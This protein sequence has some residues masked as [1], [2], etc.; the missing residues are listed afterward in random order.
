MPTEIYRLDYV[1]TIDRMEIEISPLKIKYLKELMNRFDTI[2]GSGN[3]DEAISV[4][5]E[6]V[7]ISMQQYHPEFSHH[8]Q[9]VEDNFDLATIYKILD[10]AA[11]I[12]MNEESPAL[13]QAQADQQEATWENFD[14]AKLETEVFLLGMWKNYN[15]LETC[16]SIPELT[17]ILDSKRDLSYEEKKFS[18]AIQG[19]DL[20]SSSGNGD[21]GQKEWED[22]KARVFSGGATSDS[23]DI[24]SLQG[25]NAQKAGFGIGMGLTYEVV[26]E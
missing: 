25:I 11:G 19:I 10:V 5:T 13:E 24:L 15:E 12:K 14:L 21:R 18:A 8:T 6:C 16:I 26:K 9:D 7:R 3:D 23:N 20:D 2:K 4:M 17:A 1:Y 22:M